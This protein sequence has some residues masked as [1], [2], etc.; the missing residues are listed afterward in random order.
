MCLLDFLICGSNKII[1]CS[2]S[3]AVDVSDVIVQIN[4][5][6]ITFHHCVFDELALTPNGL[7][8]CRRNMHAQMLLR[9][10]FAWKTFGLSGQMKP[11]GNC[12]TWKCMFVLSL[13]Y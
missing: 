9:P 12:G 10:T 1:L 5:L 4:K 7:E 2:F 6:S 13:V 3:A 11:V 8:G